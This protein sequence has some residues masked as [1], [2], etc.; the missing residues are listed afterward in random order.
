MAGSARPGC[1]ETA[2]GGSGSGSSSG[3]SSSDGCSST[4]WSSNGAA[5]CGAP[6]G[7]GPPAAGPA[8]D[9]AAWDVPH[10]FITIR[11][12]HDGETL[13]FKFGQRDNAPRLVREHG[14]FKYRS[15]VG[16]W[17]GG[18]VGGCVRACGLGV[19]TH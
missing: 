16:G 1:G 13:V 8:I 19:A 12:C 4:R 15:R 9:P 6:G 2:N 18:W 11:C 10:E 5:A 3:G 7:A 14:I 17:V